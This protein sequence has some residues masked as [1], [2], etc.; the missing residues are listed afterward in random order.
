MLGE[1]KVWRQLCNIGL[2]G[3]QESFKGDLGLGTEGIV[4]CNVGQWVEGILGEQRGHCKVCKRSG[5]GDHYC[6]ESLLIASTCS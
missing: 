5:G 1:E 2:G 4:R 3:L 6:A